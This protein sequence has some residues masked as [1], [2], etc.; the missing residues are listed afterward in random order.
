MTRFHESA[1]SVSAVETA[2]QDLY[3][4]N[5][6]RELATM[7]IFLI[8]KKAK[9]RN[10]NRQKKREDTSEKLYLRNENYNCNICSVHE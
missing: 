5:I 10:K 7:S 8:S 3:Q 1:D 6:C 4:N 9:N 2:L